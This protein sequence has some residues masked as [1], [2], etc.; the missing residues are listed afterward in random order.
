M[1]MLL[2]IWFND[3]RYLEKE[4]PFEK[5]LNGWQMGFEDV[6]TMIIDFI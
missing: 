1:T 6:E 4:I 2:R 3:G 5:Q